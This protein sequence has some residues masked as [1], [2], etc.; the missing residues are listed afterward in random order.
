MLDPL[1]SHADQHSGLHLPHVEKGLH[2][3]IAHLHVPTEPAEPVVI[4]PPKRP[5]LTAG[6]IALIA[7]ILLLLAGGAGIWSWSQLNENRASQARQQAVMVDSLMQVKSGLESNLDQL[8]R[9]FSNLSADNNWLSEQ[10]A[11]ATNIIA[12]KDS[13][14]LEVK[15]QQLRNETALRTQVQRL[16]TV[17]D[18][19]EAIIAV[20]NQ[21]NADLAGENSRLHGATDLLSAQ[22]SELGQQLEAQIRRN[23]SAQYKAT[24]FRL[25]LVRRNDK[26]TVRARRTRELNLHFELN[27]VPPNYQGNQPLYLVITD[28]QGVPIASRNPVQLTLN[29]EKGAVAIIAQA[30]QMQ[31]VMENQSIALAYPLEDRLKKGT[32]VVSIYSAKGLLG[33]AGFRLV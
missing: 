8:E 1:S 31:N 30:T 13:V 32:Y 23:L 24:S 10:L 15:N 22:L 17:K 28:D 4:P 9:S 6:N 7:I 2:S 14:I 25:D 3:E 21:Q 12:Q 16:Q 11:T 18:R 29:T 27:G 19:Y 33:V 20:L 5:L 26:L